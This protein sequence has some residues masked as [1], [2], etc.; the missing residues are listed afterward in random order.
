MRR[1]YR[2]YR[3]NGHSRLIAAMA[4]PDIRLLLACAA[5]VGLIVGLCG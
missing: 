1:K 5:A 2:S 4:A 3:A